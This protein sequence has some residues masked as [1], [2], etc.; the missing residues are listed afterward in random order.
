MSGRSFARY[1][2]GK[3]QALARE[4]TE[5]KGHP[6][7]TKDEFAKFLEEKRKQSGPQ[8]KRGKRRKNRRPET[9]RR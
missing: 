7:D 8:I 5:A 4:F 3:S 9:A 1:G 6:P 2:N